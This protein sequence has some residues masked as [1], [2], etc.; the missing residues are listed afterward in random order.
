MVASEQ[1]AVFTPAEMAGQKASV[2]AIAISAA[3][4]LVAAGSPEA[5]IRISD[6]RTGSKVMKLRGHSDTVRCAQ[7]P[8]QG[9]RTQSLQCS[10][11]A[12]GL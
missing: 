8:A 9:Q 5:A 4:N 3:G 11:R 2:Y 7:Q 12:G 1:A 10:S 6:A